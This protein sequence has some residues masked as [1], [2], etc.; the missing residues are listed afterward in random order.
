MGADPTL[1]DRTLAE[2]NPHLILEGALVTAAAV[3][4]SEAIL[5][6]RRDWTSAIERLRAAVAEAEAAHLAGYLIS[7]PT[8][9][10]GLGLGGLG[11][12]CR[13]RGNGPH[14]RPPG[15]PRHAAHPPALPGRA[16]PVGCADHRPNARPWP[17]AWIMG[18][19][20]AEFAKVGPDSSPAPS[21]HGRGAVETCVAEVAL[22]TSIDKIIGLAGGSTGT[23]K[24]AFIG[25]PCGAR[26]RRAGH[27][28]AYDAGRGGRAHRIRIGA[29]HRRGDVHGRHG[30]RFLLDFLGPRGAARPFC[31]IGTRRLVE[32]LDRILAAT[33]R[34]D[35]LV[36]LRE[37]SAK[38]ADTALCRPNPLRRDRCSPPWIGSA[39]STA[40]TPSAGCASPDPAP[41]RRSS[42]C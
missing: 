9:R 2:G 4:A 5:A 16:R 38:I 17:T 31:R 40:P 32:G 36:L 34:P 8:S 28:Y 33:P 25:G 3:G 35:D 1:G 41:P 42:R 12:L 13:R 10:S 7:A 27:G 14:S 19:S 30:A 21:C 26:R 29:R 15:R 39:T 6:V 23:V 24:A 20:A 22:G 37:L 18:H 11:R